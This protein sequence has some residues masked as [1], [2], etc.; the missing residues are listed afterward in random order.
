MNIAKNVT[1]AVRIPFER[2]TKSDAS[3]W[4]GRNLPVEDTL[5]VKV[6][7]DRGLQGL[8]EPFGLRGVPSAGL[9]VD[10][11][12]VEKL[13]KHEALTR[14]HRPERPT[15]LPSDTSSNQ[16]DVRI[17][18][19]VLAFV[20]MLC[21]TFIGFVSEIRPLSPN[22]PDHGYDEALGART[23]SLSSA[24]FPMNSSDDDAAIV[25]GTMGSPDRPAV[26]ATVGCVDASSTANLHA[27]TIGGDHVD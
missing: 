17:R 19:F 15:K 4:A 8:S 6:T 1:F 27:K 5:L 25:G 21:A 7:T 23:S 12:P 2:G 14:L 13:D 22:S 10:E 24:N 11:L 16:S 20:G 3:A 18:S 9:A 26:R